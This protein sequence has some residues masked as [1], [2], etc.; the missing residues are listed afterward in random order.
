MFYYFKFKNYYVYKNIDDVYNINKNKMVMY[1]KMKKK[2]NLK[3]KYLKYSK[4]F[5][6]KNKKK[7]NYS[8]EIIKEENMIKDIK[9]LYII[10]F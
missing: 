3:N 7:N 2:M 1:L 5:K 8:F 10:C 4:I 6:Y 9:Y